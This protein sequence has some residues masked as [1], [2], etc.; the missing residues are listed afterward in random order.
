MWSSVYEEKYTKKPRKKS[1]QIGAKNTL[2]FVIILAYFCVTITLKFILVMIKSQYISF[3]PTNA[4]VLLRYL[5]D[6][7]F[8]LHLIEEK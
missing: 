4:I 5:Y 1:A 8:I 7:Y 3:Y 2:K 6:I